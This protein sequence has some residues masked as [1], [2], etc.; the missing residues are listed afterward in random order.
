AA[1]GGSGR[2]HGSRIVTSV[3]SLVKMAARVADRVVPA[4]TGVTIL[5]YHRVGGGSDSDVDLDPGVFA[6]Q[7]AHLVEHHRVLTLDAAVAELTERPPADPRPGVVLTFDDGTSDFTD[8]AVPLL[9][10]HGVPATLYVATSFVEDGTE[11]PWGAPPTSWAALRD[12]AATGLVTIGSHTHHHR[13]LDRMPVPEAAD[14]L[15]RSI[16]LIGDRLGAAP[17]H[18]AYP[19]AVPPSAPVEIEVRR[20]F[21]SAALAGSRVNRPGDCDPGRLWRTPVQASD[22]FDQFAAKAAGG[23]RLEGVL[24]SAVA[25]ARYRGSVT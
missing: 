4:P 18:F 2:A 15:D 10:E 7:L 11:F 22:S 19:K 3:K 23:M 24:R 9:V 17:A 12:A 25:G 14:D 1:A 6:D 21:A 20:R 16:E 8:V 5:I 13:L